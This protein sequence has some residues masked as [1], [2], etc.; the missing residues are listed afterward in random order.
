MKVENIALSD[1]FFVAYI[2]YTV[3]HRKN[4]PKIRAFILIFFSPHFFFFPLARNIFLNNLIFFGSFFLPSI[5][6]IITYT[7]K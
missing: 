3:T 6:I 1:I 5:L 2:F 4:N 7:I